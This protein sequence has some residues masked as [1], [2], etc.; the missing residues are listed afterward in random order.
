MKI[1]LENKLAEA[2]PFMR[3]KETLEEQE[4][5]GR[6]DDLY[7]AFGCECDDGWYDVIYGLCAEITE[8]YKKYDK[9]MDIVVDQVKEKYGTLRF[10]YHHEGETVPNAVDYPGGVIRFAP[11]NNEL[12]RE[13]AGIV[14]K[15]E[16]KSAQVCEKCGKAGAL[17]NDLSW[18]L[19][20]CDDCYSKVIA[21]EK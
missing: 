7:G 13:I 14:V 9:P 2:F 5:N 4:A 1:E 18:V 6:I 15:W 17:R 11:I 12:R 3:K 21:K 20:L 16:E 10:Y 8:A 19:T